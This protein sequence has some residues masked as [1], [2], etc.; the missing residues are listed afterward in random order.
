MIVSELIDKLAK[1]SPSA[2]IYPSYETRYF[3]GEID[4][5]QNEAGL[6]ILDVD[7]VYAPTVVHRE[8]NS[9]VVPLTRVQ[10]DNLLALHAT[11]QDA[12]TWLDE[13]PV[14]LDYRRKVIACLRSTE[15]VLGMEQSRPTRCR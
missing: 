9:S 10:R 8:N 11:L 13:V 5:Y 12:L 2:K 6:I 14:F 1:S 15:A 4:V 3:D 7:P